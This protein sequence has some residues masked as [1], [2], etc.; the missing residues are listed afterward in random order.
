MIPAGDPFGDPFAPLDA[1]P[2][3]SYGAPRSSAR[4][5]QI[6][7]S[8]SG[9]AQYDNRLGGTPLLQQPP[10]N[11]YAVLAPIFGVVVPPAGVVFGHLAL[12]QI[13]RTGQRG[14]LAAVAGLV[15]GYLMCVVLIVGLIG[16]LAVRDRGSTGA[17]ATSSSSVP[18]STPPPRVV[19]SIAPA[20]VRPRI[21][22]DLTQAAVGMCVEIQ[23]RDDSGEDALDL[24]KVP[25]E[26]R[27]GVYTV[28]AR[29][30]AES[31]CNSTYVAAPPNRA[32]AVC[33]NKY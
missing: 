9:Y 11:T 4:E 31:D 16:M 30:S 25:C 27:E 32:F 2:L 19:T 7:G 8:Q 10:L 18:V 15:V 13:K 1:G 26:H 29:E 14:W 33:L 24:F 6:S 5:Q 28:V 3:I 22:L 12:P 17:S 21:K 20:P 23:R